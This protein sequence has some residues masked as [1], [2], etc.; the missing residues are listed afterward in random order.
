MERNIL[1]E[2]NAHHKGLNTTVNPSNNRA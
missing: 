2:S 1:S